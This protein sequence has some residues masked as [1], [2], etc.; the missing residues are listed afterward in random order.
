MI[1]GRLAIAFA[2][3][4]LVVVAVGCGGG[5]SDS[6]STSS[7]EAESLTPKAFIA[8]ADSICT[9]TQERISK[10]YS[11]FVKEQK[12]KESK[13]QTLE[14]I[15]TI[16]IPKVRLQLEALRRLDAPASLEAQVSDYL[17]ALEAEIKAG[18]EDAKALNGSASKIFAK[19]EAAAK[20]IGFKVC[21]NENA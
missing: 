17:D 7:D 8:K 2:F 12:G 16:G 14:A 15:E 4:A 6:S 18:E 19:S 3:A 20:G 21:A 11:E 13:A 1:R 9:Q 10:K 5:G